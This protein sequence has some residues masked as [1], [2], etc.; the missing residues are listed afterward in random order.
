M[1]GAGAHNVGGRWN[2]PGHYVA[3]AGGNLTLSMLELLVHIDDAAQFRKRQHV[4]QPVHFPAEAVATLEEPDLPDGWDARP[5]SGASQ[6]AGDE[7]IESQ[8]SP[9]LAVP[10]VIVPPELRYDHAYMN[11]LINPQHPDYAT[12][13]QPSQVLDLVWDPRL[14][15]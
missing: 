9:V 11:Y 1:S 7:W 14:V 15:R 6:A 10:S 8:A 5:E 3:Y 12:T 4:Y 2:S 13:I